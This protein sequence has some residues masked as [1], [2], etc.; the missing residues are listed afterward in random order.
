MDDDAVVH[1]WKD[2]DARQETTVDHPAG[3]IDLGS[4]SKLSRR[5]GLLSGL[6]SV[7][8]ALTAL[9]DSP[10]TGTGNSPPLIW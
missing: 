2:P 9:M 5:I 3:D 7:G 8:F 10:E 1:A 6:T 4:A